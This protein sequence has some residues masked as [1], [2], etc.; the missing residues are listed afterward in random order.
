MT[1]RLLLPRHERSW[2]SSNID[3]TPSGGVGVWIERW[4]H[5]ALAAPIRQRLIIGSSKPW[6]E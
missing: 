6:E 3:Q 4:T 2:M 1:L 5:L